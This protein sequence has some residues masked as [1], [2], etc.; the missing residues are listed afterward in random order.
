MEKKDAVKIPSL[1]YGTA[2]KE[3]KTTQLTET[4]LS[5]GFRAID[6]ANQKKHYREDFV[7]IGLQKM[8]KKGIHR[9]S[10]FLQT[11][12]TFVEAQDHRLPYDPT[13]DVRT[14][15]HSSFTSSLKNLHTD[16]IDSFLLHGPVSSFGIKPPDWEAWK[17]IEEL[18][19]SGKARMIGVSNV[20][21]NQLE[22]W[23]ENSD[24]KPMIV[25]N[26]C[27]ASRGWDKS[28]REFCLRH[29]I[30]YQGF[31]LLTANPQVLMNPK[32][33]RIARQLQK[34][35]AQVI[36]RFATQIGILPLTGTT[37]EHHMREDLEISEFALSSEEVDQILSI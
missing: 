4:A 17:A 24:I 14:Q 28:V 36:F 27:Y 7:G 16:Y 26:R 32:V 13:S 3:E 29:Q 6:T 20:S 30:I 5:V 33:S 1:I 37:D 34:T 25:Q 22:A 35:P 19:H 2:W 10:L 18:Y 12:Y 15:V 9:S 11:K 23:V 21:L 8:E 31:S